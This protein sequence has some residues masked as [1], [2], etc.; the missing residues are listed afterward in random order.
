MRVYIPLQMHPGLRVSGI[1]FL[2]ML[3]PVIVDA[4]RNSLW[5]ANMV[6]PAEGAASLDSSVSLPLKPAPRGLGSRQ[7]LR[8]SPIGTDDF[9]RRPLRYESLGQGLLTPPARRRR[10][11]PLPFVTFWVH[12]RTDF[13]TAER[14]W[15]GGHCSREL[16][17]TKVPGCPA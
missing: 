13:R 6:A 7:R 8:M 15:P 17:A 16:Y 5:N 4:T 10:E 2:N 12:R 1:L 9:G 11:K 14:G 3:L